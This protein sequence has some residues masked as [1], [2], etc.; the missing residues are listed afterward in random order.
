MVIVTQLESILIVIILIDLQLDLQDVDKGDTIHWDE[1]G[2]R[3][4]ERHRFG[5]RR[6]S[7]LAWP[8]TMMLPPFTWNKT[9]D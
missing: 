7:E 2:S 4:L 3:R 8:F 9:W 1:L 5:D 6:R